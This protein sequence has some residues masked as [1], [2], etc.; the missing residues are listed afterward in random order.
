MTTVYVL[1]IAIYLVILFVLG[2]WFSWWII[3]VAPVVPILIWI[4]KVQV[5]SLSAKGVDAEA[6]FKA[7]NDA[8]AT[9]A[10]IVGGFAVLIGLYFAWTNIIATKEGQITDRFYKAIEQLGATD[11]KGNPK[12][13]LRLGGIYALERI[14][15][16]SERDHWPIMEVL[17]AYVREHDSWKVANLPANQ[18]KPIEQ[19]QL[20]A[21][22]AMDIQA[23]VTVIGRREWRYEK[24]EQRLDLHGTDLHGA[25]LRGA[26]LRGTNLL[27][28]N[29]M[30]ADLEGADLEGADLEAADLTDVQLKGAQL[31]GAHLEDA[32]LAGVNL[33]GV[34]LF[35]TD[36]VGAHLRGTQ[37]LTQAQINSARGNDKT[38]LPAGI[39]MPE[40]WKK[41]P[42]S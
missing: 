6:V 40:A 11:D 30:G 24:N 23:I 27:D 16:D 2:W 10:Q 39:V 31:W 33:T 13:E 34:N 25:N 26:H 37:G 28:A 1:V 12:L 7:E 4:P 36:L 15:R 22:L 29:L 38:D 41:K 17:T 42:S 32:D 35:Y 21:P 9:L 18:T 8:R 14:A 19:E 20:P 5:S 3:V